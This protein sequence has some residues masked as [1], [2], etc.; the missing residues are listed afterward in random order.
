MYTVIAGGNLA[1]AVRTSDSDT[2]NGVDKSGA[3]QTIGNYG[4]QTYTCI[5]DGAW[6]ITSEYI[7]PP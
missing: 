2:I 5:A 6:W 7:N 4:S 1:T 3:D